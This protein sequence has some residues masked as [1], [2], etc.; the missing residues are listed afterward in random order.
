MIVYCL[1]RLITWLAPLIPPRVGYWI[2]ERVGDLIYATA[3]GVRAHVV[4]NQHRVLGPG[5]PPELVARNARLVLRNLAK[6]YFDQFRLWKLSNEE[7]LAMAELE[8]LE[9]LDEALSL[10]KGVILVTAHYGSPEL[11]AQSLAARGYDITAV[12]EHIQP[13]PL[14]QLMCTLRGIHGVKLVPSDKPM[15]PILRAL[16]R[17]GIVGLVGDRDATNSGICLPF[18]GKEARMPDGS[19]QLALR[20]GAPLLVA[21]SRRLPNNRFHAVGRPALHLERGEDFEADVRAGLERV[22]REMEAFIQEAPEQWVMTVPL[23]RTCSP[24]AEEGG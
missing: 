4:E 17:N 19:V 16:R 5:A 13:E 14:F 23:W 12:V 3:R 11:V 22:L 20:T 1:Y 6:N 7:L 15:L 2:C 18:F 8:G 10:G 24:D 9:H 21:Y